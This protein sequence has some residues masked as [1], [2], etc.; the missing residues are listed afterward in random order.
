M[1]VKLGLS[2]KDSSIDLEFLEEVA[3]GWRMFQNDEFHNFILQQI[4]L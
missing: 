4:L 2:H 1:D 3:G